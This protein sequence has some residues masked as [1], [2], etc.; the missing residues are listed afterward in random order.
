M[1]PLLT[2]SVIIQDSILVDSVGNGEE[3]NGGVYRCTS[4]VGVSTTVKIL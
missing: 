4:P 3:L 1:K 2:N